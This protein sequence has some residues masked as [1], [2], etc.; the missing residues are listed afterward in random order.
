MSGVFD[1][2]YQSVREYCS[3]TME[4]FRACSDGKPTRKYASP[5]YL[6]SCYQVIPRSGNYPKYVDNLYCFFLNMV[7]PTEMLFTQD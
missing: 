2:E 7:T 3:S 5:F 4:S 6:V 1:G